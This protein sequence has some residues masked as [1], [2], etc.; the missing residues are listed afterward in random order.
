MTYVIY[1]CFGL[2][3]K[4]AKAINNKAKILMITQKV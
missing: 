1:K 3:I 2:S 4:E